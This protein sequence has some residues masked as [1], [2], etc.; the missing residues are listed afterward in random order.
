MRQAALAALARCAAPGEAIVL[1]A[2]ARAVG[3]EF[4]GVREQA[5]VTLE[6]LAGGPA[7]GGSSGEA[8]GEVAAFI[9]PHLGITAVC[10]GVIL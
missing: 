3:D 2:V 7:A 10:W 8:P 4:A 1:G 5:V 6:A 9:G